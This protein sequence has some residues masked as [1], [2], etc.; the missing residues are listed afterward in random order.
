L[1]RIIDSGILLKET[2]TKGGEANELWKMRN[3]KD[4]EKGRRQ[5]SRQE[6]GQ[7]SGEKDFQKEIVV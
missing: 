2:Q 5:K 4:R 7:E 1:T 6:T 3:Q